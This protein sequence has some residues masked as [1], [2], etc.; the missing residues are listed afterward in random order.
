MFCFEDYPNVVKIP[1]TSEL[2]KN[3]LHTGDEK[4]MKL[5]PIIQMTSFTKIV[6]LNS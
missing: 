6:E 5:F 2:L 4:R 1:Y 3:G